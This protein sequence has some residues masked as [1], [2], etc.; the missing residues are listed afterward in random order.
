MLRIATRASALA[1]WQ[2]ERVATLLH[3]RMTLRF[4]H[5]MTRLSRSLARVTK[6]RGHLVM[7]VADS[8]LCG[9]PI[10]NVRSPNSDAPGAP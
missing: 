3:Q 2:A 9:V 6:P 1:R 7:V 10:S 8:Q 5:D 4:T